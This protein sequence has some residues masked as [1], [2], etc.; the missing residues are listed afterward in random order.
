MIQQLLPD[1]PNF[2][3]LLQSQLDNARGKDPRG[4]RWDKRIIILALNLWAE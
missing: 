1:A 2:K 4:C 3:V